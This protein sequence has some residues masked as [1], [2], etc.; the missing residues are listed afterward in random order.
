MRFERV[1]IT[2]GSDYD[3]QWRRGRQFRDKGPALAPFVGFCAGAL[4]GH[5]TV[6][7]ASHTHDLSALCPVPLDAHLAM[8]PFHLNQTLG[9]T[10]RL[11]WQSTTDHEQ[12]LLTALLRLILIKKI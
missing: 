11:G 12:A 6:R 4:C 8:G 3:P 5:S 7:P 1:S 9:E 2:R 10:N